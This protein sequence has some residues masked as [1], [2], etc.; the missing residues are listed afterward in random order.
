MKSSKH[1]AL[2]RQ[3]FAQ[4]VFTHQVQEAAANRNYASLT[5]YKV[6]GIILMAC[7]LIMFFLQY[8]FPEGQIYAY[9]GISL[10]TAKIVFIII[11]CNFNVEH[12]AITHKNA[13]LH[14]MSLRDRYLALIS[15]FHNGEADSKAL[16]AKRDALISEYNTTS[17]LS[18]QTKAKDYKSAQKNL[19]LKGHNE[20][21]TWSD[22]EIDRF[23]PSELKKSN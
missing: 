10:S 23:L 11:Q 7:V 18:I 21:Y 8:R 1:L 17:K 19:G 20:Q 16:V 2:I 14:Y 9:L 15:D 12:K 22:E 13:A 5:R 6:A 4:C 3:N